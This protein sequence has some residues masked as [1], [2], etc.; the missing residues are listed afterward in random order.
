MVLYFLQLHYMYRKHF[1]LHN[2]IN[3]IITLFFFC[4]IHYVTITAYKKHLRSWHESPPTMSGQSHL[5]GDLQV[6]PW[7][8]GGLHI[9]TR[10]IQCSH[11]LMYKVS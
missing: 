4:K 3:V 6:P 9:A 8:H 7:A 11:K 2:D 1:I 10:K 5:F